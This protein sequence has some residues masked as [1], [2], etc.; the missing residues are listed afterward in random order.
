MRTY[1]R[2]RRYGGTTASGV[3]SGFGREMTEQL[4]ERGDWVAGTVR[5]L[6]SVRGLTEKYENRFWVAYLDVTTN[7]LYALIRDNRA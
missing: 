2:C 6:D 5:N 4:L 3:S 1:S 7:D